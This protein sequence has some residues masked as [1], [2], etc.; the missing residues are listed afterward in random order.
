MRGGVGRWGREPRSAVAAAVAAA[1]AVSSGRE[2][3]PGVRPPL[4]LAVPWF[5]A[6]ITW[7]PRFHGERRG[8]RCQEPARTPRLL[9]V[10]GSG[11][12]GM[13]RARPALAPRLAPRLS[14]DM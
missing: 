6:E 9:P 13:R 8:G 3:L 11:T 4:A 12:K 5:P 1:A 10:H 7:L 14:R 2:A